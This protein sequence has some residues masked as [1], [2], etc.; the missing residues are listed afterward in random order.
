MTTLASPR[1]RAPRRLFYVLVAVAAA[2]VA[3]FGFGPTFYWRDPGL[4]PLKPLLTVH[5]LVFTVWLGLFL[6]QTSLV[7]AGRADLHRRLGW[8]S[9]A[10][11]A[12]MVVMGVLAGFDSLRS[13]V[14]PAG[15]DP[16]MFAMLPF[17]DIAI[18]AG[19]AG[20]AVARRRR[21]DWHKRLMVMATVSLLTAPIARLV[22]PLGGGPPAFFALTA[23]VVLA[24]V[25][26]D[27]IDRRRLHPAYAW[28]GALL[29]LGKPLL[30]FL[31]A[32]SP[33]W[34]ALMDLLRG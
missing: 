2:A 26:F 9:A 18:F 23:V 25:A 11:A 17:G 13:G 12:L 16:R 5:G 3:V 22:I 21:S 20:W 7:S 30:L 10:W 4:G 32:P 6:A 31:V 27:W 15:L 24:I 33:P 14:A 19:L 29:V 34:L 1:G 28:S 8:A